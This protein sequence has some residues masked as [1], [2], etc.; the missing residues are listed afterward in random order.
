MTASAVPTIVPF[1]ETPHRPMEIRGPASSLTKLRD[2][3]L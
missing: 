1:S 2:M 3:T